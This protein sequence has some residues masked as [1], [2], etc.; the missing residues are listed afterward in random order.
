MASGRKSLDI[1]LPGLAYVLRLAEGQPA[2]SAVS[3]LNHT[4]T[5]AAPVAYW[6]GAMRFF[7]QTVP[8]WRPMLAF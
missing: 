7:G 2:W 8:V 4:L 6:L 1:F 3:V 5:L